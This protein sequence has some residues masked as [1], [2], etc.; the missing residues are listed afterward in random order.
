MSH[1]RYSSSELLHILETLDYSLVTFIYLHCKNSCDGMYILIIQIKDMATSLHIGEDLNTMLT[2]Y[3]DLGRIVHFG[4]LSKE[5]RVLTDM[6][7]LDPQWLIDV[8]K[9]I[10]TI[11]D[12]RNT[13]R[14]QCNMYAHS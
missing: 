1:Y 12:E 14:E 7:I 4:S 6:V 2:F 5:K 8:F 13:V 3:H 11:D 10:I 9:E